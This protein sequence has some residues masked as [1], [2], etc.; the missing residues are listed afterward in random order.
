MMK[1]G[2]L[3]RARGANPNATRR[4]SGRRAVS[5]RAASPSSSPASSAT[6]AQSSSTRYIAMNRFQVQERDGAAA[7][8]EKKWALRPSRLATMDGFR[9]FSLFRKVAED[10]S[11]P[12]LPTSGEEF[13]YT[14][15]TV[16]E[17]KDNFTVWREG[18]AF[19]EAHGG[20]TFK[21][22]LD[23]LVS[24]AR[25]LK[26]KPK[27]KMFAAQ[28]TV[29]TPVDPADLPSS[30]GG[31]REVEADGVNI[32]DPECFMIMEEA[33][34]EGSEDLAA[35][36]AALEQAAEA[37]GFKFGTVLVPDSK[38]DGDS[39]V[40]LVQVWDSKSAFEAADAA[41][42]PGSAANYFE[43]TLVLT[44]QKGA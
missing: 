23:M 2:V 42:A 43:G 16:W 19:K 41:K 10:G 12:V 4:S 40:S 30:P 18:D 33:A 31:W 17:N 22:V 6:E 38:K 37:P 21:G 8:F 5:V 11:G 7:A 1:K 44:T 32:L 29:S 36:E 14:S 28:S 39:K 27:A 34:T 9:W 26:G 15:M 24:S 25:T 3:G 35:F 13:N 20:G